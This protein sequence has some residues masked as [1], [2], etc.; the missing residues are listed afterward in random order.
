MNEFLVDLPKAMAGLA[1]CLPA[2][3][4]TPGSD[5]QIMVMSHDMS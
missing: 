1:F 4:A 5:A 3:A 2:Q